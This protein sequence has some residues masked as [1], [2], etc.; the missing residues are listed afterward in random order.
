MSPKLASSR[1]PEVTALRALALG[2]PETHEDTPW[3]E[4]AFKVK[5][6]T[7]LFPHASATGL[8]ASVKLPFSCGMALSLPFAAPT[9]YGLGKSGWVTA[10]FSKGDEFP[11][12]LLEAWLD[13]SYRAVAPK[14][15]AASV[16]ARGAVAAPRPAARAATAPGKPTKAAGKA[17]TKSP[18]GATAKSPKPAATKPAKAA[19][20]P[21]KPAKAA[22][23][24]A[25][26]AKAAAKPAKPAKA[27]GRA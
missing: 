23:K 2:Y 22:A 7:F 25:K 16:P 1:R 24:P 17:T 8:S 26:P 5:G 15:L 9:G 13:E 21:A 14:K 11:L 3:G 12:D 20:K 10:R 19:A 18:Q 27:R 6:K 4:S